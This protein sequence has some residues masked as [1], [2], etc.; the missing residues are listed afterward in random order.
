MFTRKQDKYFAVI[1][2]PP[3]FSIKYH[4]TG[5]AK[6]PFSSFYGSCDS[7]I[8]FFGAVEPEIRRKARI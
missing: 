5:C 1:G 2:L 8:G 6:L 7:L 3:T 4:V